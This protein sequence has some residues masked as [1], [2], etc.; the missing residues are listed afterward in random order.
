[1]RVTFLIDGFN[2]DHSAREIEHD[3]GLRVKWLDYMALFKSYLYLFGK[4][5]TMESVYYFTA[6]AHHLNDSAKIARHEA[7][8]QCLRETGVI[9]ILGKFKPRYSRCP[10]CGQQITRHEEKATDVAIA[11]KLMEVFHSDECDGA[12]VVIGDTD[13]V[14]AATSALRLFPQKKLVFA[15]LY[16]RQNAELEQIAPGSF[17]ISRKQYARHQLPNPF[18]LADGSTINKPTSW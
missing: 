11:T 2:V 6:L 10:H 14:P 16:G 1:M 9:D 4:N 3:T 18:V 15:F 17:K 5:A 12:V 7:Y 8:I 13:T